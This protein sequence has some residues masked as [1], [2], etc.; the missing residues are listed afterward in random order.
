MASN[1]E[2]V[3]LDDVIMITGLW[4]P[5][6]KVRR[7]WDRV[8]FVT[9]I[10][11]LVNQHLYVEYECDKVDN[12]HGW[13]W[14]QKLLVVIEW[15]FVSLMVATLAD[16]SFPA[17]LPP[18]TTVEDLILFQLI[19]RCHIMVNSNMVKTW[20]HDYITLLYQ[21]PTCE[22]KFQRKFN[23]KVKINIRYKIYQNVWRLFAHWDQHVTKHIVLCISCRNIGIPLPCYLYS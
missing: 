7:S 6:I 9:R 20:W 10:H 5:I 15:C 3:S 4:I 19:Q 2:N 14:L 18:S 22:K 13:Y 21:S 16:D 12:H 1:A 11:I 17:Y 23:E 8:T